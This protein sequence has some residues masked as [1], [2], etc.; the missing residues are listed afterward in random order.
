MRDSM[1]SYISRSMQKWQ[2]P[3]V[4]VCVVKDGHVIFMKGYGVTEA[5]TGQQVNENTLFMIGSNTKAFTATAMAELD[6]EKKLSLDDRVQKWLPSFRLRDSLANGEVILRDLLCHRLGLETFQGDFTYWMS[7]L[8]R[9]EVL[10]KLALIRPV[11]GFRTHYG[12]T[13]AAF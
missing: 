3:A 10:Q 12:Y 6:Y 2:I 7:D 11:Y 8:S 5:G 9:Q 13:N 4:A 1:D